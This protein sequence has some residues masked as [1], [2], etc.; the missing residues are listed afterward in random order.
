[1]RK[2]LNKRKIF[3]CLLILCFIGVC[4]SIW[5][6]TDKKGNDINTSI[7]DKVLEMYNESNEKNVVVEN[8]NDLNNG[9]VAQNNKKEIT[10]WNLKLVNYENVLAEDFEVDL[11][12]VDRNRKFDSR[13]VDDLKK[14]INDMKKS[15]ISN[16]WIQSAYRSVSRQEELFENKVNQYIKEGKTR[17]EAEELTSILINRPGTSEHNL[18]L[19]IDFNYVDYTFENGEGFKWLKEN[20]EKYGF[21]LRYS[22]EKEDITRVGYEPWHWRYVGREHATRINELHMCLEEYIDYLS[23]EL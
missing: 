15:G 3:L 10:D 13:A 20:A 8:N 17:E 6:R 12:T 9:Q 23:N 7:N 19:A 21:I 18:G 14:M 11:T 1:M 5:N 22:R 2:K 16:V 4:G